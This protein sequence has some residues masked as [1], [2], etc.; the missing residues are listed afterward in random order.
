MAAVIPAISLSAP[1][2]FAGPS[3]PA[4]DQFVDP[5]T[6]L[7]VPRASSAA[8]LQAFRDTLPGR[9]LAAGS[10]SPA[11]ALVDERSAFVSIPRPGC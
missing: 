1:L 9:H 2:R 8:S 11:R 6:N 5:A 7:R 3:A 4:F 10:L